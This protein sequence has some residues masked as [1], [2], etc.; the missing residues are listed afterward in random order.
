MLRVLIVDDERGLRITMREFLVAEGYEVDTAPDARV[1]RRLLAERSHHVVVADIILPG[2]SGLALLASVAETHPDTTA[3]MI[4]GEPSYETAAEA[5]RAG[6][7]DYLAKPLSREAF[8]KI[9]GRA[10][11]VAELQRENRAYR[12]HLEELVLART[13]ELERVNARLAAELEAHHRTASA[14]VASEK[15]HRLLAENATDIIWLMDLE[16]RFE[17]V[18]PSCERILGFSPEEL[19]G[20]R[21]LEVLSHDSAKRASLLL[22]TELEAALSG[23]R[24]PERTHTV[25][26]DH[27][28]KDGTTVPLEVTAN[29]VRHSDGRPESILGVSR[30]ISERRAAEVERAELEERLRRSQTMEA[31]GKMAGGV[32]HEFNDLLSAVL[33]YASLLEES[34]PKSDPM[35]ADAAEIERAALRA[36]NLT[37]KLLAFSRK[38]LVAPEID[39]LDAFVSEMLPKLAAVIGDESVVQTRP[40][41]GGEVRLR[42]EQGSGT[43]GEV[44]LPAAGA[45]QEAPRRSPESGE[46][47]GRCGTVLVAE[48]D[49]SLLRLCRRILEARGYRVLTAAHG[50][51]A[52]RLAEVSSG[53]VDLLVA[54][55]VMPG[56]GGCELADRLLELVPDLRVL[57]VAGY[58]DDAVARHGVV[59]GEAALLEKPFTMEQLLEAVRSVSEGRPGDPSG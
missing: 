9:V 26:V 48:D 56:M 50:A 19:L 13:D 33:G 8:C 16:G 1:A 18:S 4:T 53:T 7:F 43:R 35:R 32:A 36:A 27:L 20:M 57:F 37:R 34:L 10:A 41:A 45:S 28:H 44:F 58:G 15:M 40:E 24:N 21:L 12:D 5:V 22:A 49:P 14:L 42:S 30:D 59:R 31:M 38:D 52:L 11:R 17:Y 29:F 54:D 55:V 2:E 23:H 51:E 25:E 46:A 6:A 39:D 47:P 3:I